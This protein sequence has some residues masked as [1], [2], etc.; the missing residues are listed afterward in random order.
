MGKA[1]AIA[2]ARAEKVVVNSRAESK[3]H[4]RRTAKIIKEAGGGPS[5]YGNGSI[6]QIDQG[7]IDRG[8]SVSS[9]IMRIN[10]DRMVWNMGEE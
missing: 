7:A 5:H 8:R 3:G 2:L 9:S 4:R 1:I 6:F 10:R